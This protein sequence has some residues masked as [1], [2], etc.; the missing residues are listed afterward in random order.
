MGVKKPVFS[1]KPPH[2]N[3]YKVYY[4][5]AQFSYKRNG[6]K[7]TIP[8]CGVCDAP[9]S[10]NPKIIIDPNLTK[11]VE[12]ATI[13]EE[14]CHAFLWNLKEKEVRPFAKTVAKFLSEQGWEKKP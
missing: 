3:K 2:G 1:F 9:D 11:R 7:Q 10:T 12:L 8:V 5:K 6:K 14:I 13:V 4:G